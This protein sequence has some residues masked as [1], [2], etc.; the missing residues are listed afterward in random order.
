MPSSTTSIL[1]NADQWIIRLKYSAVFYLGYLLPTGS[2]FSKK[3]APAQSGVSIPIT[4]HQIM[5]INE[6][7]TMTKQAYTFR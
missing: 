1:P 2:P 4:G 7:E 3:L 5:I 6:G